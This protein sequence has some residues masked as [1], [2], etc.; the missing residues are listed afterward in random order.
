MIIETKN[1]FGELSEGDCFF[2]VENEVN[3]LHMKT[4]D[5]FISDEACTINAVSLSDG[6]LH[7]YNDDVEVI[8][9]P[10]RVSF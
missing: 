9:I 8:P 10:A 5:A 6:A 2:V 7:S 3:R 4:E 1:R